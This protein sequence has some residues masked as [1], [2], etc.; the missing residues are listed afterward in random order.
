MD[1]ENGTV[2][3]QTT[4]LSDVLTVVAI[5]VVA[6]TIFILTLCLMLANNINQTNELIYIQLRMIET[7]LAQ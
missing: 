7:F 2:Y 5:I 3:V 1:I 4:I 6:F